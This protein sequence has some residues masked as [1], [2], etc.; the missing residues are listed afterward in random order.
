VVTLGGS[1]ASGNREHQ[2]LISGLSTVEVVESQLS[3]PPTIV[4]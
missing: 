3:A 1:E 4:E 2:V